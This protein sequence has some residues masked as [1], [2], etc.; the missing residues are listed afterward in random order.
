MSTHLK[1]IT[2]LCTG[3]L[4][5]SAAAAYAGGEVDTTFNPQNFGQI[6]D[7]T[8]I[9]N[10][11]WP[12]PA[13]TTFVY[14]S[15]GKNG[16]CEVNP[17]EVLGT[18]AVD[19]INTR[20]IHD[21]VYEDYDC[22]GNVDPAD[23][24]S[25][26]TT[27]WYAQD[28]FGNVWYFGEATQTHCPPDED[29]TCVPSTA[30]SWKAGENGA[31]PGIVMLV[32]PAQGDFYRQE[33]AEDAQDMAKVLRLNAD[34][35]LT[36]DNLLGTDDYTGCLVTKEWSP[37]EHG[38]VEHKYYCPGTGLVLINEFQSGTVR[39]ELVDITQ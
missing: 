13:G 14:R 2:V 7:S 35:S 29:T 31:E 37:L 23:F 1:K 3:V 21:N 19:N 17:V 26:E 8:L 25:E 28:D 39:T 24:L 12:L 27:D 20:V 36:F 22:N 5:L 34:V 18:E 30:G 33:Y 32:N 10:Q 38:A 11:Y 15:I 6:S 16:D 4:L 9:N